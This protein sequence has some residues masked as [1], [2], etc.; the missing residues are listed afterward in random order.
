MSKFVAVAVVL[1]A[2]CGPLEDAPE[3]EIPTTHFEVLSDGPMGAPPTVHRVG[4][5]T[6]GLSVFRYETFGNEGFWTDAARLP[7]G[8]TAARLTAQQALRLGLSIDIEALDPVTRK[9]LVKD[10]DKASINAPMLKTHATFAMLL[11]A[12]A[13]IGLVV[14]D[15]NRDGRVD[16]ESGDRLG[17]SCAL[18]HGITDSAILDNPTGGSIGRRVDGQAVH[19]L[20]L[21][22]LLALA[23][24]TRAFFPM[25][26]LQ[27]P[28]G[29]SIGRA[30]SGKGLTKLSTEADFD[31][32]F[33]NPGFFPAG[34]FDETADGVGNPLHNGPAFRADLAAPWGSSGEID[35][36]DH[37]TNAKYTVMLD[38]TS[39][40]TNEGRSYLHQMAGA[41]GDRLAADY[42]AV[43]AATGVTGFPFVSG[44]KM[45]L[46]GDASS[47]VGVRVDEQK[48]VDLNGYLNSLAAPPGA[49]VDSGAGDRGRELFR[50]AAG[51]TACH[52][53]TQR[54]AVPASI[55]TMKAIFPGDA[56]RT[57]G[58][59][60]MPMGPQLDMQLLDTQGSTFDDD[61]VV[62]NAALRGQPRGVAMPLLIDLSRKPAFLHDDSVPSIDRLLDP[63]RG[64]TAPHPFYVV[65]PVERREVERFLLRLDDLRK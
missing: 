38:P 35:T 12:N 50:G 5:A 40:L 6:R 47:P 64:P 31:A 49:V 28:D 60:G 48:L 59:R 10:L 1:V 63:D 44:R 17:V 33:G 21:G 15:T 62:F 22:A 53:V 32:Y 20:K 9:A 65:D 13:V 54:T 26:Q 11:N 24:N 34:T 58:E 18:C 16:V 41:A 29:T 36:L 3:L 2:A 25:A 39:L 7:Q 45:G 4:D 14:R 52:N 56:P 61:M 8:L 37:F 43:L 42:A 55:V 57:M 46:P 23:A 30:P 27:Q 19:T 51:C